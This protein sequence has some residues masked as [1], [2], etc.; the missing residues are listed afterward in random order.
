[1][2]NLS[3]IMHDPVDFPQPYEFRPER[4]IDKDTGKFKP[5]PRV[6]RL[7]ESGKHQFPTMTIFK[8]RKKNLFAQNIASCQKWREIS[9]W[10]KN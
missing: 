3:E 10:E 1:M 5:H 9:M 4:F 7:K 2:A 6:R 8:Q